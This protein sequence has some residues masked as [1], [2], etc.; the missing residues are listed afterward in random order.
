[1]IYLKKTQKSSVM[2]DTFKESVII[3]KSFL[4][5]L[6]KQKQ[7]K[8]VTKKDEPAEASQATPMADI[9]FQTK[10]LHKEHHF[11]PPKKRKTDTF[12]TEEI[13]KEHDLKLQALLRMFPYTLRHKI[14]YLLNY[15]Y[16]HAG[17]RFKWNSTFQMGIDK[18]FFPE[19]NLVDILTFLYSENTLDFISEENIKLKDDHERVI[20]IPRDVEVFVDFLRTLPGVPN[21]KAFHFLVSQLN[22]LKSYQQTMN[23]LTPNEKDAL[24][25]L[26]NPVVPFQRPQNNISHSMEDHIRDLAKSLKLEQMEPEIE[27]EDGS[28]AV[29]E[30]HTNS[31]ASAIEE[32][33]AENADQEEEKNSDESET[34]QEEE[35]KKKEEEEEM[36]KDA[37]P[38]TPLAATP[39]PGTVAAAAAATPLTTSMT[40]SSPHPPPQVAQKEASSPLATHPTPP[41]SPRKIDVLSPIHHVIEDYNQNMLE[42]DKEVEND[43]AAPTLDE[44]LMAHEIEK[45][46]EENDDVFKEQGAADAADAANA[47]DA[48]DADADAH[49]D[50]ADDDDNAPPPPKR[51]RYANNNDLVAFEIERAPPRT[52]RSPPK[53]RS[54]RKGKGEKKPPTQMG[55]PTQ[56]QKEQAKIFLEKTNKPKSKSSS[57]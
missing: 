36:E 9:A 5:K 37:T 55:S 31:F 20:G 39:T 45:E 54:S 46:K 34:E 14:S 38:S 18:R 23:E 41:P 6:V 19:S 47:A 48:A 52:P 17:T 22:K 29:Q 16:K 35:E 24:E 12:V 13:N 57:N 40:A 30:D 2:A 4:E 1:M 44:Q 21:M 56:Y 50:E 8:N 53:R 27:E 42:D 43:P 7:N 32:K 28:D 15:I 3:P 51:P 26:P 11:P 25:K 10:E 49:I 33:A